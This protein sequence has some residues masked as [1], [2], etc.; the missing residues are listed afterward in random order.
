MKQ[1]LTVPILI[2][3]V[4]V[5]WLLNTLNVVPDVD[6]VWSLGLLAAGIL[7][8]TIGGITK[9]TLVVGPLLLVGSVFSVLRQTGRL[10]EQTEIP[11]LVIILGGLMLWVQLRPPGKITL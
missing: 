2:I 7:T 6:W 4:G 5:A 10:Q 9:T 11:L 8:L 3:T 1:K